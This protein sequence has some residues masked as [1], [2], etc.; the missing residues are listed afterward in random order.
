VKWADVCLNKHPPWNSSAVLYDVQS[1]STGTVRAT[2]ESVADLHAMADDLAPAMFA[3]RGQ[4]VDRTLEAIEGVR[5]TAHDHLE[6]FVVVIAADFAL[7]HLHT[8]RFGYPVAVLLACSSS[9]RESSWIA[10]LAIRLF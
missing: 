5:A 2:V 4:S 8:S 1:C 3:S 7:R 10:R 6:G 9:W